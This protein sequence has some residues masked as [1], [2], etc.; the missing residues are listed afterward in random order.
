MAHSHSHSTARAKKSAEGSFSYT[1]KVAVQLMD[2]YLRAVLIIST[3]EDQWRRLHEISGEE[4]ISQVTPYTSSNFDSSVWRKVIT[5][6]CWTKL[7]YDFTSIS[8]E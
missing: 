3:R 2:V 5:K 1:L 7:T 4:I 8:F 6:I